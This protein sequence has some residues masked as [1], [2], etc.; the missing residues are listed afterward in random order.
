MDIKHHGIESGNSGRE[1]GLKILAADDERSSTDIVLVPGKIKDASLSVDDLDVL[2]KE[3]DIAIDD[4][5][6]YKDILK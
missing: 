3:N 6:R 4:L 5:T 1:E 2:K